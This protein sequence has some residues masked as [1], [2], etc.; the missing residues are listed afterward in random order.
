MI[1]KIRYWLNNVKHNFVQT[2]VALSFN[3][4]G[5][6]AGFILAVFLELYSLVPGA[7]AF[8]LSC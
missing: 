5:L 7:I 4:G 1:N 2:L 3:L 8:F 6:L